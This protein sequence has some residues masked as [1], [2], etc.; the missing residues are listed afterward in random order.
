MTAQSNEPVLVFATHNSHKL[1]EMRALLSPVLPGVQLG[2]YEGPEPRET[3]VSFAQNALI[4]ARAAAL[5][6]GCAAIADDSGL[7]VDVL[8]GAPGIFSARWAGPNRDDAQNRALLLWQLADIAAEHRAAEFVCALALVIPG[9]SEHVVHGRWRGSIA[10]AAS[11]EHGFGY[12]PIFIPAGEHRTA[13]ELAPEEKQQ[14]SHR[15]LAVRELAP[16]LASVL[17]PV[18]GAVREERFG[19]L[20]EQ[21]HA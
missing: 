4:K 3:G 2:G 14:H 18:L 13:A 17:A 1:G 19:D 7:S 11:G 8:G 12:D 5:H 10:A 9:G 15:S 21:W 20:H 6:S 16:V